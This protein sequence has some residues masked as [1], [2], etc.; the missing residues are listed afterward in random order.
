MIC[1]RTDGRS[2]NGAQASVP[3]SALTP[4]RV[5]ESLKNVLESVTTPNS[6]LGSVKTTRKDLQH[7]SKNTTNTSKIHKT[8]TSNTSKIHQKTTLVLTWAKHR[9][10]S[11]H[12]LVDHRARTQ[13][14]RPTQK[15][16]RCQTVKKKCPFNFQTTYLLDRCVRYHFSTSWQRTTPFPLLR[17][18]YT[19]DTRF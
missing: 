1:C 17:S 19:T 7:T 14:L 6:V 2:W 3:E 18:R 8:Y 12:V 16:N 4:T 11:T 10:T 13:Q 9:K 5:L 15:D